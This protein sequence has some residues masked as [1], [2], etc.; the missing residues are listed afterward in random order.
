MCSPSPPFDSPGFRGVVGRPDE[1]RSPSGGFG[2]AR[3]VRW[4]VSVSPLTIAFFLGFFFGLF[5]A[6]V[7]DFAGLSCVSDF[8]WGFSVSF[9]LLSGA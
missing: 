9:L 1:A 5:A 4:G 6:G 2:I 8:E 3:V 7:C